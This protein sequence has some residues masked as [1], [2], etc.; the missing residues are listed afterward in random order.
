MSTEGDRRTDVPLSEIGGKGVFATEVQAAVLDGRADVAVHSAKD[1]PAVTADALVLAAVPERGDPRTR[2]WRS[3]RRLAEGAVVATGSARRRA[4]AGPLRPDLGFAELRGNMATRLA[5]SVDFDAIVVAA[6][7]LERLGGR[8]HHR[9]PRVD[10]FVPQVGQGALAIECRAD[11]GGRPRWRALVEHMPSRRAS[12]RSGRSSRSSAATVPACRA[13]A[14][15]RGD[16]SM[17]LRAVLAERS[18]ACDGGT[19]AAGDDRSSR[20]SRP[21]AVGAGAGRTGTHRVTVHLVG[22]GPG[23]P[24]LLTVRGAELLAAAD[25]VVF[26]RLRRRVAGPRAPADASTSASA[27]GP[28]VPQ[29]QIND[30]LVHHGAAGRRSSGSRAAIR[31]SSPGGPRRRSARRRGD[32]LRGR[33]GHHLGDRRAA[34]AGIPVTRATPPPA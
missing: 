29:E 24:G 13:H 18:A 26:D 6:V 15:L 1:L 32:R 7:A 10:R 31:S 11:E 9:A 4:A 16:G 34:Y 2:S 30:L 14:Q 20:S 22:A 5:K 25:V 33:A 12:M 27:P 17:T 3:A 23:D 21:G 19:G 28:S 8:A